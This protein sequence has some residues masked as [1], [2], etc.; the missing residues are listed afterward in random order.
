MLFAERGYRGTSTLDL[1][2]A[3]GVA[4]ATLFR[5]FGTKAR[6]F[7]QAVI[8]PLHRTVAGVANR[9]SG[10]PRG[11]ATEVAAFGLFD[12]L[13]EVLFEDAGLLTAALAALTFEGESAEFGGLA[14]A[15]TPL[16]EYLQEVVSQRGRERGFAID[17][18]IAS[19]LLV[20]IP[21]GFALGDRLLFAPGERPAREELASALARFT[22]WGVAGHPPE[23]PTPR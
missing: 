2:E 15:F 12:E 6:L 7:E 14:Q 1:A 21:L 13:L 9:R 4:E 20:A 5:H 19:R 22:A 3:A 16:L 10:Q 17:P 23:G 11:V 18:A 8:V